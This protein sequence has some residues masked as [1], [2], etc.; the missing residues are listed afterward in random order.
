MELSFEE[1]AVYLG[2]GGEIGDELK[3]RTLALIA[4]APLEPRG[5]FLR[6]GVR[7][8]LCGTVG[9]A[10]DRWQRRLAA[11]GAADALIAQAIGTAAVEKT[12]DG[13]ERDI[14]ATLAEGENLKMRRSPGYG[15]MGLQL[16]R[17]IIERLDAPRRI[18]VSFTDSMTLLPT[19]SVTAVCEVVK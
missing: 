1:V 16:N 5:V 13:I 14:R 18:G 8:L 7:F 3:R 2:C 15:E 17:E 11:T 19:K 9:G 4:E 12:M 10:F 6:D